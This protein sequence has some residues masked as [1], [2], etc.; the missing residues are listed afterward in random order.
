MEMAFKDV[1]KLLPLAVVLGVVGIALAWMLTREMALGTWLLA[2]FLLGHG[3]V[4]VMF[5]LPAPLANADRGRY[6]YPFDAA[7]SHGW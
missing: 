3:L 5:A 1:G 6:E 2:A 4:H 7:R